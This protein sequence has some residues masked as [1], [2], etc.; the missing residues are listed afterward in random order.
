MKQL[1]LGT[2][3]LIGGLLTMAIP[4]IVIGIVA[5]YQSTQS[6]TELA[7][8][9]M[10]NTA[11]SLAQGLDN[12][13]YEQIV[14][15][16]NMSYQ[17]SV[18]AAAEKVAMEGEKNSRKEIALAERALI[19]IKEG[20]G[21]RLSSV[22]IVGKDGIFI[23]SSNSKVFKGTNVSAR[24]YFKTALKGTPNI[25]AV[26][27]SVTT[28]RVVCTAAAPVYGANGKTVTGVAMMAM[29]IKFL[30]DIVD[31]I[32]VS[33]SGY[34]YLVDKSGL[35]ITHPVKEKILKENISKIKGM[36]TLVAESS[37]GK[38]GVVEYILEGIPKIAAFAP[39][40]ITGWTVVNSVP[41]EELYASSYLTRNVIVSF[42]VIFLVLASVFFFFFAR[43]ATRPLVDLVGAAQKIAAGDLS[44]EVTKE[45]RRDEIGDL[46]RAFAG[47]IQSLKDK[48]QIAQKIAGGDLTVEA[49]SLSDSDVL[50][51][52][53]STMV[54]TLRR[55]IEEIVEGVNVLASSGSE[56]MASVS[57]LTAGA[58]E[59][60]TAV[61]ETT[62]TVEEVKQT[63]DVSS[64]KAKHVAELGR[65]SVEISQTGLKS[66]EDTIN[67][68]NRI[69]EQVESIADMVVRLSEQSQAIGEIIA[70]VNDLAEQ[71]NLLAVNASIEAAKAGEQ[72]KGFAV[73]AQEIRSLA[74]QSK[75]ATTQVRNILF[76]VQKAIS[77]AVMATELGSRAVEEGVRLSTQAGE[78]IDVL[79][80]SVSES[81][82]AAIQIAASSQQQLIGM[83]QVVSAMENIR[84]A[85]LQMASST[86]QTEK[87]AHDLHNLGQ[88]LQ[89][90]VKF[91]RV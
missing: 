82:N 55:Q 46:A 90:I 4:L 11:Q 51:N 63:T 77:S 83:D 87:S 19:K 48:A 9:S 39:I 81:T 12:I 24:E 13:L 34:A 29:E 75:Q 76:D 32:K 59:T 35:Y 36:E 52:A 54:A 16:R 37:G 14:T 47:M 22:N 40:P 5:V 69:K 45:S 3:L 20:G 66:I 79:A 53:F 68:M 80:Q 30:T 26:V 91:Y 72:G 38:S 2:K 57:Q 43:N 84:E 42:G 15:V 18:I 50:G 65:K 71:S 67:G 33:K 28:G 62:T 21:E 25:G 8:S 85:A 74:A 10:G 49:A 61:S 70:T 88:R 23:A 44:V 60:S 64:Q 73:V 7:R 56:I 6:I 31:N 89:E 58:A 41:T 27:I 78:A 17:N 86:K 1:K